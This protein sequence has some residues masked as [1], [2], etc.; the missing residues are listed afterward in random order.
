MTNPS[1]ERAESA[2]G[3]AKSCPQPADQATKFDDLDR[4]MGASPPDKTEP[5]IGKHIGKYEVRQLLGRGGMGAVYLGYDPLI[6]R[7]VAIKVLPTSLAEDETHLKRFLAEARAVGKLSHSNSIAIYDIGQH[8]GQY[9]IVMELARGGSVSDLLEER[10]RLPVQEACRVALEAAYGLQAAHMAG[11]IHR[12]VKPENLMLSADGVVKL[13][14]FGLAKDMSRAAELAVT[15]VGQVLGTP[16]YMSPEQ[17]NGDKVDNRTDIY[18]WGATFYHLLT[19]EVPFPGES[20]TKV[21]FAHVSN[22]R[23]DPCQLDPALPK[24]CS[25]IIAKAM[26]VEPA[27]RYASIADLVVEVEKLIDEARG[28]AREIR[29]TETVDVGEA[30]PRVLVI[31]P[32]KLRS[33]VTAD[34][35]RKAGCQHV[36]CFTEP[37]EA[38]RHAESES[39]DVAIASRQLGATSGEEVLQRIN[40]A[41]PAETM[42]VL[43]SSDAPEDLLQQAP[44]NEPAA[45]VQK[46]SSA[47]EALRAVYIGSDCTLLQLP[48]AR[49]EHTDVA[50]DIVTP[51]GTLMPEVAS[52]IR[53]LGILDVD[54]KSKAEVSDSRRQRNLTVWFVTSEDADAQFPDVLTGRSRD[55]AVQSSIHAGGHRID[56]RSA[57]ATRP[58]QIWVDRLLQTQV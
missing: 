38:A 56:E 46:Q 18:S 33:K 4:T 6:E 12:D 15:K 10:A 51:D 14:D 41:S 1:S 28:A 8:D 43:S 30:A 37:A 52:W 20:L 48:F 21:L 57:P 54:T 17:I 44:L 47:D 53:E 22:P 36:E 3:E 27:E 42:S 13:V 31:E 34:V 50:L 25:E 7:E 19:G 40:A 23:P 11:L 39:V 32:S 2:S 5:G 49:G 55:Q 29:A 58:T 26:A 35:F 45:Y 16:F 24:A 9:Y